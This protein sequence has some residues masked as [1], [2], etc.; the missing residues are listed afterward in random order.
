VTP[1][2][3]VPERAVS[4]LVGFV[5]VFALVVSTVGIVSVA[6]LDTLQS[7]RDAERINNAERAFEILRSNTADIYQRGAPS[8]ATEVSLDDAS[9]AL[10]DQIWFNVS[11]PGTGGG[12]SFH[13]ASVVR[14]IVYDSGDTRLVY[15]MGAVF[16]E[17]RDGG[18]VVQ[19]WSPVIGQDR[20]VIPQVKTTSATQTGQSVKSS[21]VLIRASANRRRVRLSE[22]GGAYDDVWINVSSTPR[23]DLWARMLGDHPQIDCPT[24]RDTSVECSMTDTP[25]R[26]FV[27]ET[28]I[29]VSL[30]R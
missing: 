14:P 4:D 29:A 28:W 10:G 8:R 23:A 26:L 21:T 18:V 2:S 27:T 9:L 7:A 3:R 11:D 1:A 20:T 17:Q 22:T 24:V 15:V 12:P 13:N 25:Q 30:K 19:P 6:G 16:R 5:L